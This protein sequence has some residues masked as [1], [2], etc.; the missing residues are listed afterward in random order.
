MKRAAALA[1]VAA[2][3]AFMAWP[4]GGLADGFA[5]MRLVQDLFA[6]HCETH[7][8]TVAGAFFCL[9]SLLAAT[10]LPGASLLMLMAGGG[11]GLFWGTLLSLLASTTGAT[12]SM[13]VARHWLRTPVA[14][15]FG[16]QLARIDAGIAREGAFYLFG[17]RMAPLIP[18]AI[19]NPLLG[20]TA[21][22]TWTYFWASAAG[23]A[24]GT[25]LY[26]NAGLQLARVENTGALFAPEIVV[27]LALLGLLPWAAARALGRH[28]RRH[29][30]VT[31][32]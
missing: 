5:W 25:A 28:R 27:S 10:G 7:P 4:G 20:L 16:R 3:L 11:F 24:A 19:L 31:G 30:P 6:A 18:F 14:Q 2:A 29:T 23:M 1:L 21:M 22:P 32:G 9:F 26:V 15:R 17:L 8:L 13:L 12:L